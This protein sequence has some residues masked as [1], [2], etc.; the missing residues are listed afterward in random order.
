[1]IGKIYSDTGF[2][3]GKAGIFIF[4]LSIS[5]FGR[6]SKSS[7]FT[8]KLNDSTNISISSSEEI[9]KASKKNLNK[10]NSIKKLNSLLDS[11][12]YF[13]Y[14]T[15]LKDDTIFYSPGVRFEIDT[16]ILKGESEL[17]F[18]LSSIIQNEFTYPIPYNSGFLNNLSTNI[19]EFY[20][21]SGYP[22]ASISISFNEKEKSITPILLLNTEK[23]YC[24]T[25]PLLNSKLQLKQ[26]TLK[27]DLLIREGEYFNL[28][29][30]NETVER[31]SQR[32]YISSVTSKE[33]VLI[34]ESVEKDVDTGSSCKNSV[35]T[36]LE[37]IENSGMGIEGVLGYSSSDNGGWNGQVNMILQNVLHRGEALE[38]NYRGEEDLQQ[39]NLRI[40]K[41]YPFALPFLF[42]GY[43]DLEV[44]ESSYGS[45]KGGIDILTS[46]RGKLQA[47]VGFSGHEPS[48]SDGSS[49]Y[50]L[51]FDFILKFINQTYGPGL[52]AGSFNL[53]TGSGFSNKSNEN[54]GRFSFD[55]SASGQVSTFRNQGIFGHISSGAITSV[56][57]SLHETEMIR[58]GGHN[59]LRG[60]AIDEFAFT[61]CALLQFEYLL[62]FMNRGS[63]F[64]F[65][66]GGVGTKDKINIDN[67]TSLFGY[68]LGIRVPVRRGR[69]S[70]EYARNYKEKKSPGR[71]HI[72]I[73]NSLSK[74]M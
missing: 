11:L 5:L 18:E 70:L 62:Y 40:D 46:L 9:V 60:Y 44:E 71:I 68:G 72:R 41:A 19:I 47:G 42:S 67:T 33:P 59:S 69:L 28:S 27:N 61:A 13:S 50:T 1:M 24:F 34:A 2:S 4:I 20:A 64:I 49:W 45:L 14:K 17:P 22:F 21:D 30:I 31:L 35:T 48:L 10:T 36:P 52:T 73:Q 25:P 26:K 6:T 8:S 66:D 54:Y 15:E 63:V 16:V 39:F 12:G 65:A 38:L 23:R 51:G 55:L 43:F 57:D 58:V 56:E 37:I 7:V 3:L 32:P 53:R 29:R 74:G